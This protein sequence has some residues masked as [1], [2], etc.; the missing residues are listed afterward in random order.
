MHQYLLFIPLVCTLAGTSG[1][2]AQPGP[3]TTP[4][5]VYKTATCGCCSVWVEHMRKNGLAVTVHDVPQAEL[6]KIKEK[7]GVPPEAQTCHTALIGKYVVEGHVPADVVRKLLKER[8]Q[9]AGIAVP[10]MPIGSPGMEGAAKQP[11]NVMTFA[12][13]QK[14]T[15]YAKK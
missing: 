7:H 13:G 5:I 1:V 11:Y 14:M 12:P 8:P 9:I 10:G 6:T 3:K 15:V 2:V 4:A